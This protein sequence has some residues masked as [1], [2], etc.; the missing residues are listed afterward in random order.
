MPVRADLDHLAGFAL[1]LAAAARLETLPRWRQACAVEDKGS[2][3]FDPVTDADR[4]AE[5]TIRALIEQRFPDHGISGEEWPDRPA[6]GNLSWSLDPVDGTRSFICGLPAWVTLIALLEDG[7]AVLGV[8]DCPALEEI[9]VGGAGG[10]RM[11]AR[12][13]RSPIQ[14]SGCAALGEARF[15]TTDPFLFDDMATMERLRRSVRVTRFG[16]DGYAYARLAAG[17][18]D[19]VVESGLKAHDYNALVPLVRAAGGHVGDWRGGGDLA[20]GD[21]VAAATRELYDETVEL[22]ARP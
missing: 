5:R 20:A 8:V 18:L 21:V 6:A 2:G 4:E 13:R 15:S 19:L 17:S 14:A 16:Q 11:I 9:Y 10:A 12:G 22:L 3:A 1:E 7:E